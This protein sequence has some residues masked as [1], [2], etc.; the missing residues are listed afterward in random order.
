MAPG[1]GV[2]PGEA[3][4][5]PRIGGSGLL[6]HTLRDRSTIVTVSCVSAITSPEGEIAIDGPPIEAPCSGRGR[7]TE[8]TYVPLITAFALRTIRQRS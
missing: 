3:V 6:D 4:Q 1:V 7:F 2:Q 5:V 8:I